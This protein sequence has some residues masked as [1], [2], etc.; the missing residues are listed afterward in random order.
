M[1]RR[2]AGERTKDVVKALSRREISRREFLTLATAVGIGGSALFSGATPVLVGAGDI[3]SRRSVADT[4][5]KLLD[6]I[7]GTVFTVGD[8]AY[9]SGSLSEFANYYH[10]TWGRHK[11]RTRPAPGNHEYHTVRASG[12]YDYF[13]GVAGDPRK[14]YYSYD[15]GNWHIVVLNSNFEEIGGCGSTS[16]QVEWLKSD[17]AAN[18]DKIGLLAYFH[19]P[20]FSSGEHGNNSGVKPL[21]DVLYAARADVVISGHDHDYERF[22]PQNPGGKADSRGIRQFVVGT[23][24]KKLRPFGKVKP[25]SQVR[26]ADAFGVLKLTLHPTSYDWKFVPVTGKTFTDSGSAR[27]QRA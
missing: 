25:N 11:A 26:N 16:P 27:C 4:T 22:A 20:L 2:K 19:H 9:D 18:G 13:G 3:A 6:N 15:L 1:K 21:W 24:G 17:L 14:G 23:G 7:P 8:N 5:A 12:Y 10:P